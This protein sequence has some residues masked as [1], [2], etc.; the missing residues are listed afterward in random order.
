MKAHVVNELVSAG[1][2]S[3][4]TVS[5][6]N[7]KIVPQWADA[8]AVLEL[9]EQVDGVIFDALVLNDRGLTWIVAHDSGL[10]VD[11]IS[12]LGGAT[13]SVLNQNEIPGTVQEDFET[14]LVPVIDRAKRAGL[15][16]LGGVSAAFGCTEEGW[17]PPDVTIG[18]L[19]QL[20]D[21]GVDRVYLGDSTGEATPQQIVEITGAVRD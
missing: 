20:I 4:Q 14:R 13:R 7:P 16:V 12:L 18:L 1:A 8:E 9:V 11:Q 2:K 10:P 17:T 3:V 6:V 5:F 15:R 21:A 19:K